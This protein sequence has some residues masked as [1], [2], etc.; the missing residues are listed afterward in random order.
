M[1]DQ[2]TIAVRALWDGTQLESGTT[3][4]AASVDKLA[5]AVDSSSADVTSSLQAMGTAAETEFNQTL[6][7]AA[8]TSAVSLTTKA[9]KFKAVGTE[10]GETVAQGVGSGMT[11]AEQLANVGTSLTSLLAPLATTGAGAIAAIG[12][13]AGAALITN[14]IKGVNERKQE[15]IDD[16]NSAFE[17]IEVTAK[18]TMREIRQQI[19][20]TFDFKDL[21]GDIGEGDDFL[22]LTRL[23]DM[24]E[25]LGVPW[26]RLADVLRGKITPANEYIYDL[27]KKQAHT[28]D[29]IYQRGDAEVK[30]YGEKARLAQDLLEMTNEQRDST[31]RKVELGRAELEYQRKINPLQR[32]NAGQAE[33]NAAAQERAAAA[34][35]RQAAALERINRRSGGDN[36]A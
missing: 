30:I 28:A 19:Y 8:D 9:G 14:L 29:G 12:L 18:T 2:F 13:G 33:R 23:R 36:V 32:E 4:A 27:L 6:P 3:T 7:T 21:L 5:D 35:E 31:Q 25:T 24:A 16:I 15:F 20:D 22:G 11:G 1:T 10:L 26:E 17:S 34:A